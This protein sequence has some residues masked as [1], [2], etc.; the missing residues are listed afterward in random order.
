VIFTLNDGLS[1]DQ[2]VETLR[3]N[4]VRA[5]TMGRQSIRFVFHLDVNDDQMTVLLQTLRSIAR[6][7]PS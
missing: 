4:G 2:F 6:D 5:G 3:A 1:T 7:C